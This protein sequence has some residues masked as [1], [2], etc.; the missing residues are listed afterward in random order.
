[1]LAGLRDD[2]AHKA[3][4]QA[5]VDHL[6]TLNQELV[7]TEFRLKYGAMHRK[8]LLDD[9]LTTKRLIADPSTP[10]PAS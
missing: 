5:L 8:R 6:E 4:K 9:I 7:D 10:D 1:M 2:P 3:C